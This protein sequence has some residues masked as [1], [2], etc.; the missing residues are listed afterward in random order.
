MVYG[1]YEVEVFSSHENFHRI[2]F[3]SKNVLFKNYPLLI[4]AAIL[5]FFLSTILIVESLILGFN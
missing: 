3:L 5:T 4:L 1:Q 2:I